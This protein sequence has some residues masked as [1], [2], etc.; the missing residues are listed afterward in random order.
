MAGSSSPRSA[1][2]YWY[3]LLALPIVAVLFPD[4]YRTGGPSLFGIP[5][6]YWYQ[7]AWIGLSGV[8]TGIVYC[9]T[10]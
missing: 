6:F 8:T 3:L 2:R 10:R 4:L 9:A 5:F 1:R 7:I